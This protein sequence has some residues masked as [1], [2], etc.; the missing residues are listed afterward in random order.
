MYGFMID[1]KSPWLEKLLTA[2]NIVLSSEINC[3][4][5][6]VYQNI[7][8]SW[9][10]ELLR[11]NIFLLIVRCLYIAYIKY[12]VTE[13]EKFVEIGYFHFYICNPMISHKIVITYST[14]CL[15]SQNILR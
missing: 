3:S 15:S 9:E 12:L 4:K 2:G 7:Y 13:I 8:I 6:D 1:V 10:N 14:T 11:N 5:I